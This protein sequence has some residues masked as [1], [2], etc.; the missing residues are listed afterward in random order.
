MATRPQIAMIH[1]L[2][3]KVGMS[4]DDYRALLSGFGVESSKSLTVATAKAVIETLMKMVGGKTPTL[5]KQATDTGMAT[6][7]Q[8]AKI[9]HLWDQ[10][11]RAPECERQTALNNFL[12]NRFKIGL[13][14]WLPRDKVGAVI[15]TL[16]TMKKQKQEVNNE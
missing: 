15:H 3:S 16:E 11:S 8:Q 5:P 4:D 7:A 10:V 9:R 2:K 12:M 14:R 1:T 13:L 6:F